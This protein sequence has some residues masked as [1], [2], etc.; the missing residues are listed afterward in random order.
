MT[1]YEVYKSYPF[2]V[3]GLMA[4]YASCK[5]CTAKKVRTVRQGQDGVRRVLGTAKFVRPCICASMPASV[6]MTQS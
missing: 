2:G 5:L 3:A 1:F 4:N 6:V